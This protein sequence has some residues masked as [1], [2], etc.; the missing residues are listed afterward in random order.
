MFVDEVEVELIAGNGG[1]IEYDQKIE[2]GEVE[3]GIGIVTGADEEKEELQEILE[4]DTDAFSG[5]TYGIPGED[6]IEV[7][8]VTRATATSNGGR[9]KIYIVFKD[10]SVSMNKSFYIIA[11]FFE[12][13]NAKR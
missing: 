1:N 9:T 11:N 10:F 6:D 12:K 2:I 8:S 7:D 4:T 13:I 5:Y 3:G